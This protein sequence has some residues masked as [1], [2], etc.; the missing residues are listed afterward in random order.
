M[1]DFHHHRCPVCDG[2]FDCEGD[3][4]LEPPDDD[5]DVFGDHLTC[6]D[7]ELTA[8]ATRAVYELRKLTPEQIL[9]LRTTLPVGARDQ[10]MVDALIVLDDALKSL[11]PEK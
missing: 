2:V 4:T 7:C 11:Q 8:G 1:R 6:G 3:C 5:G 10:W 9:Y